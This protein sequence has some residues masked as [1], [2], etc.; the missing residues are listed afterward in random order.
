MTETSAS[1]SPDAGG[2]NEFQAQRL[3][4]TCQ[5]IDKLLGEIEGILNV[6]GSKAAFPQYSADVAPTQRRTIEDYIAR[7]RAQLVRVLDG[8]GILREK[9]SIPASRAIHVELGAIDIAVEELRPHYMQGYGELP[10]A[11]ATELNGIVG[12]LRGLVSKLDRYLTEGPGQDFK[13]RLQRLE[14]ESNDLELL[15][16]IETIVADRGLVEFRTIIGSILD[17]AEDKT[18][19]IAVFGRVSSGKSSL[20]NAILHVDVLPAGVTPITAVPTRITHGQES[21]IRVSFAEAPAKTMDV[22]R[23]AE[24]AT[25][26]QNPGNAKRVTGIT[27]TLPTARLRD[28]VT[29]VDTPGLG[30]LATSGAAETLAY[31]PKCDLGVVLIDAGSTLTTE[32]LRTILALQEAATRV[33]V[34]LSKADLLNAA[35]CEKIIEYVKQNIVSECNLDLPVH[36]VSVLGSHRNL[37]DQW[38]DRQILPLYASSQALRATSLQRKVGALRESVVSALETQLR[39]RKGAPGELQNEIRAIEGRLR[40]T[41]GLIEETRSAWEKEIE[42][43]PADVSEAFDRMA[44]GLLEAWSVGQGHSISGEDAVREALLQFV[45][46]RIKKLQGSMDALALQLRDDLGTTAAALG[47]PDTPGEDEFQA[48]VRGAP[49]FDPGAVSV[50]VPR[51]RLSAIFGTEFARRR[52]AGRLHTQLGVQIGQALSIYSGVLGEW[53]RL[54][55]AR[56]A[57]TFETY[58]ERYRAQAERSLGGAGLNAEQIRAIQENLRALRPP[59]DTSTSAKLGGTLT[60]ESHASP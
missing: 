15:S 44:A 21:S 60:E 13:L 7:L 9:P 11:A 10:E 48:F 59:N 32:D 37:L 12:E 57:R 2:L 18:F 46:Q 26:Q 53:L 42:G 52:L 27:V 47:I 50:H 51:P 1:P 24:F 58:A 38:F 17:R 43:I 54:V 35:D 3:R 45:Q 22:A 56:L 33:N 19:E 41:T 5:Y 29:F 49:I 31:L 6:C 36:P 30:S 34:L 25:E 40:R 55:T 8:Q 16:K 4:I 28:G 14:Q 39:R 20:L 23:L